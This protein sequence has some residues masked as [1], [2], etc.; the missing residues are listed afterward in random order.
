MAHKFELKIASDPRQSYI[1]IDGEDA[2]VRAIDIHADASN[3]PVITLEMLI[4][5]REKESWSIE[6]VVG[7]LLSD[8]EY[9]DYLAFKRIEA[10]VKRE[11]AKPSVFFKKYKNI[12]PYTRTPIVGMLFVNEKPIPVLYA[13]LGNFD[14]ANVLTVG[15]PQTLVEL[16][17]SDFPFSQ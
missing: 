11:G 15:I 9:E 6:P 4:V 16:E 10:E 1:K 3:L 8:A 2:H 13:S 17:K 12:N 5:D 14:G 7:H